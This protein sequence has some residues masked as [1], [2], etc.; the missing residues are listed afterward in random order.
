M[1]TD[2][3]TLDINNLINKVSDF[4]HDGN[5]IGAAHGEMPIQEIIIG[6]YKYKMSIVLEFI[7]F[8]KNGQS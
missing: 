4:V 6:K 3:Y 1:D 5:M 8:E 2:T 7:T